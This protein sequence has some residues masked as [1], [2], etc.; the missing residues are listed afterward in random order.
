MYCC[1]I[2]GD[3]CWTTVES[4]FDASDTDVRREAALHIFLALAD[5]A[6]HQRAPEPLVRMLR[7]AVDIAN[8]SNS[9]R[10]LHT[11]LDCLG[12]FTYHDIFFCMFL[13][14]KTAP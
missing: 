11:A 14:F 3:W 10:L 7:H 6:P 9:K 12:E 13:S 8:T 5:A 2:L 1:G 4:A